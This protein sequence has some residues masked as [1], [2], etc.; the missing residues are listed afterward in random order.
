MGS[1][2]WEE[3]E[4]LLRIA[5]D[6]SL[7]RTFEERFSAIGQSLLTLVPGVSLSAM[8]L[9]PSTPQPLAG[10]AFNQDPEVLF[11]YAAH[12]RHHDPMQ[13]GIAEA[14][15]EP[16]LLSD[17]QRDREFGRDAYTGELLHELNLRHL[18][19][20]ALEVPSGR[21]LAVAIHRARAHGDFSEHERN[22]IRMIGDD[23]SRAALGTVLR[24]QLDELQ[25]AGEESLQPRAG[26]L[27][28]DGK[29]MIL[30]A[31]QG[32]QHLL[33]RFADHLSLE[34]L[35]RDAA[36]IARQAKEGDTSCRLSPLPEGGA[37]RVT[38][39][40]LESRA[41]S[42]QVM[43]VVEWLTPTESSVDRFEE[44]A[45]SAKL[46]KREREVA[47]LAVAGQGNQGIAHALGITATT[48]GVHLTR[49]Y[50]KTGVGGRFE[51]ARLMAGQ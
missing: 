3:A 32:A 34:L 20:I 25:Q 14:S 38:I 43:A 8:L 36:A 10:Y 33:D 15:G 16:L 22:L 47:Q 24:K 19:G 6:A 42:R 46:T 23:L 29:G 9:D 39:S 35:Q 49:V 13:T 27:I 50:R 40:A 1:P 7:G 30:H 28:L 11:S 37:L 2:S 31:D 5:R 26:A 18:L 44:V 48:V 4:F 51:L 17:V 21:R 41:R 12:Y 45:T